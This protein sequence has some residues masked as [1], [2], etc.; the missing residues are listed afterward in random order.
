MKITKLGK[1]IV[2]NLVYRPWEVCLSTV[3]RWFIHKN[4]EA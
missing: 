4:R 1:S 3:E 2:D